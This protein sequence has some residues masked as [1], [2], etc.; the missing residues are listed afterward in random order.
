MG[1]VKPRAV[2]ALALA[3]MLLLAG[4]QQPVTDPQPPEPPESYE[5]IAAP[6]QPEPVPPAPEPPPPTPEPLPEQVVE[7]QQLAR[8]WEPWETQEME[9]PKL[10]ATLVGRLADE[11]F[12]AD[13]DAGG[14]ETD[15]SWVL[16]YPLWFS[17]M[18]L[19]FD[20]QPELLIGTQFINSSGEFFVFTLDAAEQFLQSGSVSAFFDSLEL[21]VL[22]EEPLRFFQNAETD[23]IIFSTLMYGFG[24]AVVRMIYY[25]DANTLEGHSTIRCSG[26]LLYPEHIHSLSCA[27]HGL[28]KELPGAAFSRELSLVDRDWLPDWPCDID[29]GRNSS[30]PSVV[31]LVNM[32]LEGFTELPRPQRFDFPGRFSQRREYRFGA[33]VDD[34]QNVQDWIFEVAA[35]WE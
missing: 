19:N 16:T 33:N 21:M 22:G 29:F 28:V 34:V 25:T 1:K 11:E 8:I 3:I 6:A 12:L 26:S 24:G 5:P 14:R 13:L 27:E 20:G 7:P 35:L 17:I 15:I 18:D 31:T 4:C 23:T 10:F 2:L 30:D 9:W 32:V